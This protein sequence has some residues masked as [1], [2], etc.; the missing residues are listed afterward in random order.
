L[1]TRLLLLP[2]I[3]IVFALA[4]AACGSSKDET[5]EVEKVIVASATADNPVNCKKL[6]TLKFNEQLAGE[7]GDAAV[8]EC[9]KEAE[10]NEGL[11]SVRVSK[12]EVDGSDATAV[13]ALKG[14]GFDGQVIKVALVKSGDQWKLDEIVRFT[15]FDPSQ[16]AQAFE[17]QV[18]KHPG[19]L[20]NKLAS[21]IADAFASASQE[22][23]EELLLSGSS[24]AFE[25][26]AEACV[27]NPSA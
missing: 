25:G 5:G 4:F 18:A 3:L 22:E 8:E 6:N 16:L 1:R 23:A 20:S 13:V 2:S 11:D 9:E 27:N 15:K 7:G 17:E 14:G 12:V 10:N 19:E 26:V 24:K 21:C